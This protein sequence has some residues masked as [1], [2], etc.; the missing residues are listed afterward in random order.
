[1]HTILLTKLRYFGSK[2]STANWFRPYLTDG[3]QKIEIKFPYTT[4]STYSNWG[5]TEHGIPQGSILGPLFFII[6]INACVPL[7]LVV[8]DIA[9]HQLAPDCT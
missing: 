9:I 7:M 5:T 6:Y 3:K 4:Q 1:V 8:F 2:G